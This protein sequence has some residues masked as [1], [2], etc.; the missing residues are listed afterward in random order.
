MRYSL[1]CPKCESNE[2]IEVKGSSIN[3][4][5]RIPLNKWGVQYAILDRYICTSCGYTE[6]F[7]QQT[8]SFKKWSGKMLEEQQNKKFDGFV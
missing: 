1:I 7:V 5:Q 8:K 3:Q 4:Q 2:V 6:E